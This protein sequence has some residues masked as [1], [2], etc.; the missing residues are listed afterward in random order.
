MPNFLELIFAQLKRAGERVVLR[1][2]RG[3]TFTEITGKELLEE[4]Q[5][6]R[7]YVRKYG[8]LPGDRCAL[9]GA[10]SIRWVAVDLALMAEGV[11]VVPLYSRQAPAELVTMMKDCEPSLLVVGEA[12]LGES[13]GR[14]W[15]E[16]P[17]RVTMEEVLRSAPAREA[18]KEEP[19]PRPDGELTT[20]IYTS[21]TSGEAKGDVPLS[22]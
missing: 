22:G 3:Y 19:N 7:G 12:S 17:H 10:N 2:I 18:V 9:L 13:I 4:V 15:K 6:G 20:I 11:M 5:R 1:E 14:L 21:G 16:R 8:L